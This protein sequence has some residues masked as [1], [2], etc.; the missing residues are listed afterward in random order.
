MIKKPR[1]FGLYLISII[2]SYFFISGSSFSSLPKKSKV[3]FGYINSRPP[4]PLFSTSPYSPPAFLCGFLYFHPGQ[5]TISVLFYP[6][7]CAKQRAQK[8]FPYFAHLAGIYG[9]S[10]I[11]LSVISD[12]MCFPALSADRHRVCFCTFL[13]TA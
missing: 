3:K 11:F 7:G 1:F 13:S 5:K 2:L 9:I 10:H 12:H 6:S 8:I 4:L